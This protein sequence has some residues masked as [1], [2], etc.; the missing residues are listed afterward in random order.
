MPGLSEKEDR[1]LNPDFRDMLSLFNEEKVDYLVVG[2][3]AVAYHGL[4]RATGDIDLW[5]RPSD[6]NAQRVWCALAKFGA[7]LLNLSVDDLKQPGTVF[8]I[9]IAPQR[10]D[11][12]TSIAGVE[13]DEAEAE[14][15]EVEIEGLI[16][17]ILGR[18]HLIRNKK[19]VGRPQDRADVARLEGKEA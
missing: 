15:Q 16:I 3:Y 6:E 2:A 12:L 9:G 18:R 19:V 10:I 8:Q 14:R 17:P 4:P 1:L 11:I 7:P 13:F 5:V